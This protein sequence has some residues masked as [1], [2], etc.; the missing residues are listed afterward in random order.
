MKQDRLRWK[1]KLNGNFWTHRCME[2]L[3]PTSLYAKIPWLLSSLLQKINFWKNLTGEISTPSPFVDLL[4]LCSIFVLLFY[5]FNST[6]SKTLNM[7]SEKAQL[8]TLNKFQ[9]PQNYF[10]SDIETTTKK[11]TLKTIIFPPCGRWWKTKSI[12][13]NVQ[14]KQAKHGEKIFQGEN[15]Q[16]RKF[17]SMLWITEFPFEII[18]M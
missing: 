9:K 15:M 10:L 2:E 17:V 5:L 7:I 8:T 6:A 12:P 1:S 11:L 14:R 18:I 4:V 3:H 13:I 16:E